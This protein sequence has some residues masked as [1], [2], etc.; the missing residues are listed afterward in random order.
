MNA[1]AEPS[2]ASGQTF[3]PRAILA[4]VAVGVVAFAGLAVLSAYAPDLRLSRDPRAHALSKSAVGYAGV[5]DLMKALGQPVVVSRMRPM[6]PSAAAVVLTPDDM[7][8]AKTLQAYP[9]GALTLI[10][11]PK[12]IAAPDPLR[13]GF[14]RKVAPLRDDRAAQTLLASYAPATHLATRSGWSRPV[15]H[16]SGGPLGGDVVLPTGPI[17]GLKTISGQGWAPILADEGGRAVLAYSIKTPSI[18]VLAD[19]DLLN[20][21]GLKSLETARAGVAVLNAA[22]AGGRRT[23]VFDVTLNG[24]ER[25]RG[26]GRLLLEP[27]WLAATL[28]AVAAALLMGVHALARFGQP[29][30]AGRAFALGAR[31][32]VDNAADL[33]RMARKEHELAPAYAALTRAL[34]VRQSGAHTEEGW[35]DELARRR[36][37]A[38]PAELAAEAEAA[39]SRDDLLVVAQ[40]IYEWRGEMTRERR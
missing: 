37:V 11:L 10:V 29:R 1:S 4:L 19:A 12:W 17:D 5:T 21:Q 13:Q 15:L 28:I 20:N 23:L 24:L 18:W 2:D 33:A 26:L 32:L 27:P 35:L 34:V 38:G 8:D 36:G 31:A 7:L 22:T 3:S 14:V 6:R 30:R 16:G 39:K 9:K 40:K 25:G